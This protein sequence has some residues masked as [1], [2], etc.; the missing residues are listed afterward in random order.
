MVRVLCTYDTGVDVVVPNGL[1]A[2]KRIRQNA[3]SFVCSERGK[4]RVY[5]YKFRPRYGAVL[6]CSRSIYVDGGAGGNVDHR[7]T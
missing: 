3:Y 2:G 1:E 7:R 6:F 5:G 4:S